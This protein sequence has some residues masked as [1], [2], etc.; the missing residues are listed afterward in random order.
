MCRGGLA[1][2]LVACFVH[3]R[4]DETTS[5]LDDARVHA[6][7]D[8]D[9]ADRA[10]ESIMNVTLA[11]HEGHVRGDIAEMEPLFAR[12]QRAY[13]RAVW[14]EQRDLAPH[15]Y[16]DDLAGVMLGDRALPN[17][18]R[19]VYY[20]G[21]TRASGAIM[22]SRMLLALY[23]SSHLFLIHIDLKTDKAVRDQLTSLTA[24]H[25]NIKLIHTRRL[26]QW[27]AWTMVAVMLDAVKSV[28]QATLDYDFFINL[29]DADITLR[30]NDEIVSWL[31]SYKGRQFVQ[32]RPIGNTYA[33]PNPSLNLPVTL[34]QVH[35]AMGEWLEKAKNFTAAHTVVECGGYGY[36]AV[37]S[38]RQPGWP[39]TLT[40]AH[41]RA[42]AHA[43][44][45]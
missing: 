7:I 38:C 34:V 10:F 39:M 43:S 18:P 28:T 25:P 33:P 2:L 29:S 42:Q 17:D 41:G 13:K 14:E 3:A 1:A 40:L 30:T 16:V 12:C 35:M 15:L 44:P 36:V 5:Q 6:G 11:D 21:I 20:V 8:L 9:Y 22:V 24:Q 32:V 26:V 37:R 19:I 27:G 23:H 31:R 45:P 4:Q